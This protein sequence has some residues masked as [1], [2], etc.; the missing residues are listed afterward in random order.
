MLDNPQ[1][2][3]IGLEK[4]TRFYLDRSIVVSIQDSRFHI[5]VDRNSPII[6]YAS[7][8]SQS[9]H[10]SA[11]RSGSGIPLEYSLAKRRDDLAEEDLEGVRRQS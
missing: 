1:A 2:S 7:T 9:R 3:E 6:G 4:P 5:A 8:L 11:A 10:R